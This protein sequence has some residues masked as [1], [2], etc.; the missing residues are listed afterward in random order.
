M[1]ILDTNVLSE[2]LRKAPDPGVLNW[3]ENPGEELAITS[4]T[5]AEL[6]YGAGRL[7][8]GRRRNELLTAVEQLIDGAGERVLPYDQRAARAHATIRIGREKAGNPTST[9]DGMIA[10]IATVH[11]AAIATRNVT[12][13]A[14]SGV[15]LINPWTPS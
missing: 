3:L 12:H 8:A 5:V 2:P 13:F 14:G 4:V 10:A 15:Q 9:E 6:M 11:G 1:I 7:P